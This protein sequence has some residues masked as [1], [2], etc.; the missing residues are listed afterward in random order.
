MPNYP[1]NMGYT[2]SCFNYCSVQYYFGQYCFGI[3]LMEYLFATVIVWS[4]LETYWF[5]M[6][7]FA[8]SEDILFLD[9][10]VPETIIFQSYQ[11]LHISCI[12]KVVYPDIGKHK[13]QKVQ[14]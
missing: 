1:K 5:N 12:L 6:I 11:P 2:V 3:D 10:T 13:Y 9:T 7:D 4:L 8:F 14:W